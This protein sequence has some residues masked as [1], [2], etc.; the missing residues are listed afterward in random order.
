M[1]DWC[2]LLLQKETD[3]ALHDPERNETTD[4]IQNEVM[5]VDQWDA[6]QIITWI[7]IPSIC[8]FGII[9]NLL[10]FSVFLYRILEKI[11]MVEKG[12]TI[13][14]MALSMS[15]FSFCLTT[16]CSTFYENEFIYTERTFS[17]FVIMYS[18]FLQNS[19]IKISTTIT[20][21]LS[22]Y[23]HFAI[24]KISNT[25]RFFQAIYVVGSMVLISI[26]W[27][28]FMLPYLWTWEP[29]HIDCSPDGYYIM[30]TPGFFVANKKFHSSLKY[31]HA[32]VGF[33]IPVC[34][35]AYCNMKLIATVRASSKRANLTRQ[36]SNASNR[37]CMQ[38]RM[39]ITLMLIVIA[40]FCLVLPG[41]LLEFITDIL[42]EA[43]KDTNDTILFKHMLLFCNVLQVINMAFNFVLYCCVNT[44]FRQTL[45][46]MSGNVACKS[47]STNIEGLLVSAN[48]EQT[49]KMDTLLYEETA[50]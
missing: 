50:L 36:G 41:E 8:S 39:N 47:K 32:I 35:L 46:T 14:M 22:I 26:F 5:D 45:K 21:Y 38:V 18:L 11:D 20:T 37:H 43:K 12:S 44:Q 40:Y 10:S 24:S 13:C 27:I 6:E 34:I 7:I 16:L 9:G 28:L 2:G 25:K 48:P 4:I 33:F 30:L 3:P 42:S 15:D 29:K 19:S 23:R 1:S 17:M 49:T 31:L